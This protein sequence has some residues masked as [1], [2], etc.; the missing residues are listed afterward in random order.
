[1]A[2]KKT[3]EKREKNVQTA[4]SSKTSSRATS[5]ETKSAPSKTSSAK[6]VTKS[7]RGSSETGMSPSDSKKEATK[8]ARNQST[9]KSSGILGNSKATKS[10]KG[11]KMPDLATVKAEVTK[12]S[13]SAERSVKPSEALPKSSKSKKTASSVQKSSSNQPGI[14]TSVL[15]PETEAETAQTSFAGVEARINASELEAAQTGQMSTDNA[16]QIIYSLKAGA[17]IYVKAADVAAALDRT[18]SWVYELTSRKIFTELKTSHGKL[19]N[20]ISTTAAYIKFLK[21]GGED[22]EGK[23]YDLR[24]KKAEALYK[25]RKADQVDMQVKELQGKL[26]RSEDVQKMTADLLYFVRGGLLALAGRCAT[27]CAAS[28]E[29]AEIQQIIRREVNEILKELSEYKYDPQKYNE[30]VRQRTNR[31]FDDNF[32]DDDE[33][34]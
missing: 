17:T 9:T 12:D 24:K 28:S 6:K 26:H 19:F 29:P 13:H 5:G 15:L 20:L 7:S 8:S 27:E 32:S 11:T 1:M 34:E 33:S 30:L 14:D 22:D 23:A 21:N 31:D 4:K 16:P 10:T 2:A 18:E 3:N 25:E